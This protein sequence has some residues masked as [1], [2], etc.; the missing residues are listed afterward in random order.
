MKV[1]LVVPEEFQRHYQAHSFEISGLLQ[2]AKVFYGD[3]RTINEDITAYT[4]IM[5]NV[6]STESEYI[7]LIRQEVPDAT[8]IACLDYGFSVINQ[9]FLPGFEKRIGVVLSRADPRFAVNK[10]QVEW[11]KLG[12]PDK[13]IT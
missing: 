13:K 5:T 2:W 6:S 12:V 11:M 8:V 9:Y 3:V 1:C 7:S 4:H 10:N